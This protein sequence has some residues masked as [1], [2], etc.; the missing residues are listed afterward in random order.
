MA[1]SHIRQPL[2]QSANVAVG[3]GAALKRF[4]RYVRL[5]PISDMQQTGRQGGFVPKPAVIPSCVTCDIL[6]HIMY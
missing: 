3:S 2:Q 6:I 1:A 5:P 4:P